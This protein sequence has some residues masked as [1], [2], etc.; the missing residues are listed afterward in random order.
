MPQA[1]IN[2]PGLGAA[3]GPRIG[4]STDPY[5]FLEVGPEHVTVNSI[6]AHVVETE[7]PNTS[8]SR[9]CKFVL[10]VLT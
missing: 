5:T 10:K 8:A 3:G 4:L 6:S 2:I 7:V 1:S 9:T